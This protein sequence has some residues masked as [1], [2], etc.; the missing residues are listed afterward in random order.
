[1]KKKFILG[2]VLALAGGILA[3]CASASPSITVY[4]APHM[5][6]VVIANTEVQFTSAIQN[7]TETGFVQ[8]NFTV[9]KAP[10]QTD[11]VPSFAM[12]VEEAAKIGEQYIW[13]V[14]GE[15]IDGMYVI[16]HY[17]DCWLRPSKGRWQGIVTLALDTANN[18]TSWYA[19][20]GSMGS[21]GIGEMIFHFTIDAETGERLEIS[22]NSP[23]SPMILVP[24]D[25]QPLWESAQGR[26]I[27]AMSNK[28]LAKFVDV[29]PEQLNAYTHEVIRFAEAHFNGTAIKDVAM[30]RNVVT[31]N[32]L[33]RLQGIH[34]LLDT[35]EDGNIYGTPVGF[36]FTVT[37]YT[38]R[39]A[40]VTIFEYNQGY[41]SIRIWSI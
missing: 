35:D 31:P 5:P 21:W 3:A 41:R 10:W 36:E 25:T 33:Q 7:S 11:Q 40:I 19:V 32:G 13:D 15:S 1:M 22:Y 34:V 4:E 39:E 18:E 17:A 6:S 20:D 26:A 23:N 12:V 2:T 30:G 29:S 16:M 28:E 38:G 8:A 27:Q 37:D 14:F 9:A 24:H